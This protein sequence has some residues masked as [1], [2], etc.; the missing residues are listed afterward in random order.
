MFR[1]ILSLA[2]VD[3]LIY[4][5]AWLFRADFLAL[6]WSLEIEIIYW[7]T[8]GIGLILCIY[9][10]VKL[11]TGG[12]AWLQ[13]AVVCI[14]FSFIPACAALIGVLSHLGTTPV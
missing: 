3:C 8:A 13:R 2:V 7:I 10:F 6:K 5:V 12:F 11:L 14:L 1:Y 4:L 9:G